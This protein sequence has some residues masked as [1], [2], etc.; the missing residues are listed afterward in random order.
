METT[1]AVFSELQLL[2]DKEK[3]IWQFTRDADTSWSATDLHNGV[4]SPLRLSKA[5]IDTRE[6][7]LHFSFHNTVHLSVYSV[8]TSL[9]LSVGVEPIVIHL[10]DNHAT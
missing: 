1:D 6:G 10:K 9:P 4:V 3:G 5:S 7:G 2:G 8:P